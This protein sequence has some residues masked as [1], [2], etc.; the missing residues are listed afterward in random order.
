MDLSKWK[1]VKRSGNF[2][3]KV[4]ARLE[5]L[6]REYDRKRQAVTSNNLVENIYAF[7]ISAPTVLLST[8][9]TQHS[10]LDEVEKMDNLEE[11][12][13]GRENEVK[14]NWVTEMDHEGN[15]STEIEQEGNTYLTDIEKDV[16][17][18]N[19]LRVW[20]TSFR[21]NQMALKEL[22]NIWNERFPRILPDDPRTLLNTPRNIVIDN[23]G[24]NGYYWHHGLEYCIQRNLQNVEEPPTLINLNVNVDGLPVYKSSKQEFWP[25]LC[26]IYEFPEM[27]PMVIG[28][29]CGF[30][31]PKD[32]NVFLRPCVNEMKQLLK[33]GLL[34]R[35][36]EK[37]YRTLVRIR[38]FICDSPARAFIKGNTS[39]T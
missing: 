17:V 3:R 19:R 21:I 25:I 38:A 15:C 37:H 24:N 16:T 35:R 1:K 6:S 10:S 23:I 20:A 11:L 18:R 34:I 5:T 29:F 26:N 4:K 22:I 27:K 32:V 12:D 2:R 36:G 31:K 39:Y 30:G 8:E 28:I 33:N 9:F 14:N 13:E 7:N